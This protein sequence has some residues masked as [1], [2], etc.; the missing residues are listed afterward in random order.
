MIFLCYMAQPLVSWVSVGVGGG[1]GVF[2]LSSPV[3]GFPCLRRFS[4][5]CCPAL[6]LCRSASLQ[7][8]KGLTCCGEFYSAPL[9]SSLWWTTA[10]THKVL[11]PCEGISLRF[12]TLPSLFGLLSSPSWITF[13][14]PQKYFSQLSSFAPGLP[15][16]PL[17]K[18][19]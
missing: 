9:S 13:S 3:L 2:L 18:A 19:L 17:A 10:M 7:L 14:V 11:E 8:S 5:P 6:T 4:L 15:C 1:V 12:L 16:C